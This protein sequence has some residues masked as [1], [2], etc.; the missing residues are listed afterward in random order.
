[1]ATIIV[2][3]DPRLLDNPD[4]DIRYQ[5]PDLVG[6]RSSGTVTDDGY[7]YIGEGPLLLV[8][9]KALD[10]TAG[11]EYVLDVVQNVR[12]LDNDLR[13]AV[14][15]AV[16]SDGGHDVVYPSDFAGTFLAG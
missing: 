8:F 3:L 4:A 5:L 15:V 6:Q 10:L 14:V 9:L 2:R 16:E 11:L 13:R 12:V 7:D 1:M